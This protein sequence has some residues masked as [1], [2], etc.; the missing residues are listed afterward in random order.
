[1]LTALDNMPA[2][3]IGFRASGQVSAEEGRKVLS[4]AI[5]AARS[6]G[7]KLRF[8][9]F[10]DEA[11]AGY[12]SGRIWDDAVFGSRHFADFEKIAFVSD[13]DAYRRA[14]ATLDG[15]MPAALKV[16]RAREI[17]KAKAWLAK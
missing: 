5:E 11:F 9:Y 10:A 16:F 15:L 6:R 3:A 12:E 13:K 4:P 1:M 17:E 2:G 8:L 14:V 7:S